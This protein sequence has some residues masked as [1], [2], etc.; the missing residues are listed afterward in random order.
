MIYWKLP[1]FFLSASAHYTVL[2]NTFWDNAFMTLCYVAVPVFFMVNGA[3]TLNKNSFS[4][5]K[6]LQKTLQCYV[7]ADIWRLLYLLVEI[8]RARVDTGALSKTDLFNYLFFW[9][10]IPGC[11]PGHMWFMK[12]L[13]AINLITPLV[14]YGIFHPKFNKPVAIFTCSVLLVPFVVQESATF[15][16]LLQKGG[17]LNESF[18]LV[19]LTAFS[20]FGNGC[21]MLLFYIVGAWVCRYSREIL[22]KNSR[23]LRLIILCSFMVFWFFMLLTKAVV[24]GTWVWNGVYFDGGYQRFSTAGASLSLL[25][26]FLL[27]GDR[28]KKQE[29]FRKAIELTSQNTLGIYYIHWFTAEGACLLFPGGSL[30]FNTLKT[31]IALVSSLL[32]SVLLSKIP[33]LKKLV[34]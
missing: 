8:F 11:A 32:I 16:G 15:L 26:L 17:L 4:L 28:L 33:V 22:S 1:P 12:A 5:K 18:S 27:L 2:G 20:P 6:H 31:L 9:T 10:D 24:S 13:L 29:R 7:T 23:R 34:H 14:Y 21:D 3:L 30:L 25:V 19:P